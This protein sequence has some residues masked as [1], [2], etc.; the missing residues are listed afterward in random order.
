MIYEP[1]ASFKAEKREVNVGDAWFRVSPLSVCFSP[2]LSLS[3]SFSWSS[4]PRTV[5]YLLLICSAVE[6]FVFL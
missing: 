6:K 1:F 3:L 2:S 4:G 5:V